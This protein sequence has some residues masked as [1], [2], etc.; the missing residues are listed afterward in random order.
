M[1][2]EI[3]NS[4]LG[5]TEQKSSLETTGDPKPSWLRSVL[6]R[7]CLETVPARA[8]RRPSCHAQAP[9]R[10]RPDAL[11]HQLKRQLLAEELERAESIELCKHLCGAANEAASLAW[12]AAEPTMAFP[13]LFQELVE[14]VKARFD[15]AEPAPTGTAAAP[16][17]VSVAF[18]TQLQAIEFQIRSQASP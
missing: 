18:T 7:S 14:T 12:S 2:N 4:G 17:S 15:R 10:P 6:V 16:R 9:G 3:D 8:G 13:V 11:L 1:M 5:T